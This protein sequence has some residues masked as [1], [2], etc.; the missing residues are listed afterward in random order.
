MAGALVAVALGVYGNVHDP[1]GQKLFTLVFTATLNMKAWLA[2]I[3]ILLAVFQLLSALRIYGKVSWPATVPSWFGDA[4]RLSG[5]LAFFVS[6]PVAYH[7]LWS[8]GFRSDTS[9]MRTYVHSIAGCFFYGAFATKIVAVRS[10]RMPGWA[11]PVIGGSVFASLV[12]VWLT[13]SLWFFDN[14]GFPSF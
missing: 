7:C 13:S 3:A 11:L 5:T 8:L 4:H 1:T 12:I 9:D 10:H 2:T 14:A 6:L